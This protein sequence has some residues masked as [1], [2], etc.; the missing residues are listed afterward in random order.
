MPAECAHSETLQSHANGEGIACI[1]LRVG[2]R[3]HLAGP[4]TAFLHVLAFDCPNCG[5]PI[6]TQS[7][8]PERTLERNDSA[9]FR[10]ACPCAWSGE[11]LGVQARFHWVELWSVEDR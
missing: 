5:S 9:S 8:T 6:C 2:K 10:V 7:L 4:V 11:L 3:R 1:G